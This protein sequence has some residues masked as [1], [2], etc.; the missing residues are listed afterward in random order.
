IVARHPLLYKQ[1]TIKICFSSGFIAESK[2]KDMIITSSKVLSE[3][4]WEVLDEFVHVGDRQLRVQT[5][6]ADEHVLLLN[7][8]TL[9]DGIA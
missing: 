4:I 9:L 5:C 2:N 3:Y 8:F 6:P 1:T 7:N